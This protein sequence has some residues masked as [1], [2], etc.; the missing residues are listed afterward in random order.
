MK[1]FIKKGPTDSKNT[2][3]LYGKDIEKQKDFHPPL[4]KMEVGGK[5]T[6]LL[7]KLCV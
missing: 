6:R 5:T 3:T 7:V 4:K 1:Q 2:K